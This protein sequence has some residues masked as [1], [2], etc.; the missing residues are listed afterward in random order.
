MR[1]LM[2]AGAISPLVLEELAHAPQIEKALR[3]I[4]WCYVKGN[5]AAAEMVGRG[6]AEEGGK[7]AGTE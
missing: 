5:F 2:H 6:G 7:E 4:F 1:D 3:Q